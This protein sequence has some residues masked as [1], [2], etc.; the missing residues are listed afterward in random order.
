MHV[1]AVVVT[2]NRAPLLTACLSSILGQTH[3]VRSVVVSDDGSSDDTPAVVDDFRRRF[4]DAAIRLDYHRHDPPLGQEANRRYAMLHSAGPL[5]AFLDDDDFWQPDFVRR[6]VEVMANEPDVGLVAT[7]VNFVGDDGS[8]LVEVAATEDA[9]SGR[10]GLAEGIHRDWLPLHVAGPAFLLDS[11]LFRRHVL[12]QVGFIPQGS[13]GICDFALF[14]VLAING[15]PMFWVPDPL[16]NY[17]VHQHGR[18]T[19]GV[20]EMPT[21]L[22]DWCHSFSQTVKDATARRLISEKGIAAHRAVVLLHAADR[23]AKATSR[24]LMRFIRRHGLR[25]LNW[26]EIATALFMLGGLK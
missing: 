4:A 17:R 14:V 24:E 15:W 16:V 2:R 26:R 18:A 12:E 19:D 7:G 25:D 3:P 1:D 5:V 6:S 21:V 22:A 10:K 9:R 13:G 11:V 8:L 20:V 23:N